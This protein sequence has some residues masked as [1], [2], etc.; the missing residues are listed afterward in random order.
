MTDDSLRQIA[1][2]ETLSCRLAALRPE[3]ADENTRSVEAVLATDKPV[4]SVD[5][6]TGKGVHEVWRMDGC[7]F[8]ASV[9][10]FD[11][12]QRNSVRNVLGSVDNIRTTPDGQLIG[13]L[14]IS[15]AEPNVWTK[16][17]E[18]HVRDVSGGILPAESEN[19]LPGQ[20]RHVRGVAY[21]APQNREMRVVTRWRLREV[22]LTPVGADPAAK[23]RTEEVSKTMQEHVRKFLEGIGLPATASAEE[24]KKFYDGL[25][26]V[27]RK[28]ADENQAE[29]VPEGEGTQR[30]AKPTK[31]TAKPV[32]SVEL[33]E[34]SI[35]ADAAAAERKRVKELA[36][37]GAG[38]PEE[39]VRKAIDDGLSV[40]QASVNFLEAHRN[41]TAAAQPAIHGRGRE[42][43]CTAAA[44]GMGLAL[45]HCDGE[46]LLNFSAQYAP[47]GGG[48]AGV[49]TEYTLRRAHD[50]DSFKKNY[51]RL[52]NEGERYRSMS[53]HDICREAC[54]IDGKSVSIHLSPA[55]TFRTAV[56]G[57]ALSNIFTTNINAMFLTGYM[58]YYDS[59]TGWVSEADV[60]NFLTQERDTMGKFGS[61][62]KV[63]KGRPADHLDTSDW[64]ESYK[65]A[66]YGGQFVVDEQDIINDRFGA[67][68][69]ES[70]KDMGLTAAQLRPNLV[71]GVIL[72]NAALDVDNV[73]LFH[74]THSNR[75]TGGGS[76]L[77][78]TSIQDAISAMGKQR[79]NKRPLNIRPRFLITP[80]DLR[81]TSAVS[82]LSQERIISASSGGTYNPLR[83]IGVEARFDD[84][85]GV[86]GVTDPVSGTAYAG[87][88]TNWLLA[89]RPGEEGAK[90]IEVGYLRGTGRAPSVRSFVL[91]KGQWGIGW[92]IKFDI[93]AKALDFRSMYFSVGA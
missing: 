74:A 18:G 46:R 10:L 78:A 92:D 5:S 72:A 62:Q 85:L 6:R 21:T 86:G 88:A 84:R 34:E 70:P 19:I 67:I 28:L 41:R 33:D 80:Q 7:E 1:A 68:E 64:K 56:S 12:H 23:I 65:I 93:G 37:L 13:T 69:S 26:E 20:T 27:A 75:A 48:E 58:D 42:E 81:W 73:A 25:P 59:T 43:D 17:R 4:T 79:I 36:R 45:R 29:T 90:T 53:L 54:R 39:V 11:N 2:D 77:S 71:Y 22:S 57:S 47:S 83:D 40:E 32:Q 16:I 66:R 82:L 55:E 50:R 9:P 15:E 3:T 44:L 35:R 30:S 51:E 87:S 60:A 63:V 8:D 89:A 38:L 49:G 76:A 61:L 91:D 52:L 31:P 24:A 14:R